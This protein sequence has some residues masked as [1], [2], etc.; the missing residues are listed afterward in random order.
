MIKKLGLALLVSVA[1]CA[2]ALAVT[3]QTDTTTF[4]GLGAQ[5]GSQYDILTFNAVTGNIGGSGTYL[6]NTLDFT[7]GSNSYFTHVDSGTLTNTG[8]FG[9]TPFS[10]SL[11]YT[12]SIGSVTDSITLGGNTVKL[13]GAL[14]HFNTVT[15]SS[16]GPTSSGDLTAT[17]AVPEPATWGMMLVGF[18]AM[19][20]AMRSRRRDAV[21]FG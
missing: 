8:T 1:V 10:F 14:Y 18:G 11:P 7:A 3:Y 12:I 4:T 13:N 6:I 19:G 9:G 2:P 20:A 5:Y 21:S 15:L 16:D 17:V